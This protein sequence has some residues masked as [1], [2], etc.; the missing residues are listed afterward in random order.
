MHCFSLEEIATHLL[1]A[2]GLI[3]EEVTG[4]NS[5]PF[6]TVVIH[7]LQ[8]LKADCLSRLCWPAPASTSFVLF[9]MAEL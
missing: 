5:S 7:I 2:G 1:Q 4:S 9:K 3:L 6:V 8:H